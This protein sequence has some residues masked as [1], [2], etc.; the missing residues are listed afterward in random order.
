MNLLICTLKCLVI[1][2]VQIRREVPRT[3]LSISTG[4][5]ALNGFL[6]TPVHKKSPYAETA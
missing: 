6:A 1:D 2:D 5:A 3:P 4:V